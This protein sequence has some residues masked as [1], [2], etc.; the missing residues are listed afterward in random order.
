MSDNADLH[1]KLLVFLL[2]EWG[3]KD[4]RQLIGVDLLFSPGQG[5]KDEEIRKWDRADDAEFFAEHGNVE[6]LVVQIIEIADDEANAKQAGRHRFVVRTRQ[7]MGGR[8]TMSF[9]LSPSYRGSD[10]IAL[11]PSSGGGGGGGGA[12]GGANQHVLANHASQLMRINAEMFQG[13]IRVLGQQNGN[14]HEQVANLTVENA[15]LRR[16]LE[17][18]RSN[19]MDREFQIAMAAEKNA[20]TNAG[21]QK[22]LNLGSVLVAKIGA[23]TPG[24]L[25]EG[26]SSPLASLL[27]A[28][29]ESLSSEQIG[30]VMKTLGMEQ[31]MMFME[32]INIVKPPTQPPAQ[33]SGQE[34]AQTPAAGT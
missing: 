25:S 17:E 15:A 18:A 20:R 5:F 14:L 32:I 6:K 22:I 34:N 3:R 31:K 26:S 13:T 7:F 12:N 16:E 28:F 4:N 21:F 24:A 10:D 8:A 9:A 30:V 11:T 1:S 27:T 29:Y 23:G 19:K 33:P 2:T